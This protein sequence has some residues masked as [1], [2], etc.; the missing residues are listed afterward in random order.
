MY[1]ICAGLALVLLLAVAPVP[2][3]AASPWTVVD[4]GA[5]CPNGVVFADALHGLVTATNTAGG[6]FSGQGASPLRW[7]EDGGLTWKGAEVNV[8]VLSSCESPSLVRGSRI[9]FAHGF[10]SGDRNKEVALLRSD[11]LGQH[12]KEIPLPE[13]RLPGQNWFFDQRRG[14]LLAYRD[15]WTAPVLLSTDDGGNSWEPAS[16]P[17]GIQATGPLWF[18]ADG[19]EG[20]MGLQRTVDGGTTWL[21]ATGPK[22]LMVDRE[23]VVSAE[24]VLLMGWRGPTCFICCT[25]DAGKSWTES[26][27]PMEGAA[28][29][30][31]VSLAPDGQFGW[32]WGMEGEIV[33]NGAH[34]MLERTVILRTADGGTTWQRQTPPVKTLLTG[35][36]AISSREAWLAMRGGYALPTFLPG[37]LWHTVDGGLTW[38][39]ESPAG[40]SVNTMFFLDRQHGWA[41]GGYGGSPY[42]TAQT[43]YVLAPPGP[44]KPQVW[45]GAE[46]LF[47]LDYTLKED[48]LVSLVLYNSQGRLVRTLLNAAERNAGAHHEPFDGLADTDLPY[49]DNLGGPALPDGK[50]TWKL[51]ASPVADPV[52]L[53]YHMSFSGHGNPPWFSD[54]RTGAWSSVWGYVQGLCS[55]GKSLYAVWSSNEVSDSALKITPGGQKV[56]GTASATGT[57][58]AT[59]GTCV[60]VIAGTTVKRL[61]CD[62]GRLVAFSNGKQEFTVK[63]DPV[64]DP[65]P[66]LPQGFITEETRFAPCRGLAVR[67][68]K[69][70]VSLHWADRIAVC[71]ADSGQELTSLALP[72]PSGIAFGP[73]G[74]LY[75][76]TG[77]GLV[78]MRPDGSGQAAVIKAG[79]DDPYGLAV[80]GQG[81][82]WISDQ[83]EAQQVLHFSPDGALLG[84]IGARAGRPLE[85]Q[86]DRVEGD[87]RRPVGLCADFDRLYV[88][89]DDLL[90]RVV[91][92]DRVGKLL[93]QWQGYTNGNDGTFVDEEN[94]EFVYVPRPDGIIRFQLDY[95]K[96]T[97]RVDAY[98]EGWLHGQREMTFWHFAWRMHGRKYLEDFWGRFQ[99]TLAQPRLIHYRGQTYM[100]PAPGFLYHLSGP[101]LFKPLMLTGYP[102]WFPDRSVE[103][104]LQ[105]WPRLDLWTANAGTHYM[106]KPAFCWRDDNLDGVIDLDE[107]QVSEWP[108]LILPVAGWWDRQMR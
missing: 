97:W 80:D 64:G 10:L 5:A 86:M 56:W 43:V 106:P 55:D 37:G 50:Y 4:P 71:D 12:W 103:E 57:A 98:S 89:E 33:R 54:D 1:R 96:K 59:D 77:R 87:L 100:T 45:S 38:R 20:W 70:Y 9:A 17:P 91:V 88:A 34:A 2:S 23:V 15:N 7:T 48:S 72:R 65:V 40:Y 62:E 67:E 58:I 41:V 31:G 68:G 11:D 30:W 78:K 82:I 102:M 32:A 39:N 83:G 79:L 94:P 101:E 47:Y 44:P 22:D 6:Y 108:D 25:K 3:G 8:P 75:A 104:A 16:L 69:L 51:L 29:L 92:Y 13:D 81:E 93:D 21:P 60:Y 26:A 27:I 76:L 66:T 46:K 53:E 19:Q 61:S 74:M 63:A 52:R 73:D 49:G 18:S 24:H 90:N 14:V 107:Y 99:V 28:S 85:A 95:Q 84:T 36:W 35:V 42:E 105:R